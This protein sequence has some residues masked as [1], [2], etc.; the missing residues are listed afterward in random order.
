VK[1]LVG[2]SLARDLE[3]FKADL[4]TRSILQA[5]GYTEVCTDFLISNSL[6][7]AEKR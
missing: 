5:H 4:S 1:S 3:T 2:Q 6:R 7:S